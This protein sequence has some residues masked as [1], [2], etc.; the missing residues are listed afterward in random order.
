MIGSD[1]PCGWAGYYKFVHKPKMRHIP[2]EGGGAFPEAYKPNG[3]NSIVAVCRPY[4]PVMSENLF[5]QVAN[6]QGYGLTFAACIID[7]YSAKNQEAIVTLIDF[8]SENNIPVLIYR[9]ASL[10]AAGKTIPSSIATRLPA[11]ATHIMKTTYSIFSSPE[12]HRHLRDINPDAL[13]FAGEVGECCIKASAV[14]LSRDERLYREFG[15][16]FG[17]IDYGFPVYSQKDLIVP[18]NKTDSLTYLDT[19][20][21]YMFSGLSP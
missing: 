2:E 11:T 19:G 14:G 20:G 17:A 13:I 6:A 7:P 1:N 16:E 12:T 3:D 10:E 4:E 15:E 18:C 21:V 8:C 9:F 5:S